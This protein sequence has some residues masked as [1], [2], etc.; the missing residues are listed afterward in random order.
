MTL[1]EDLTRVIEDARDHSRKNFNVVKES[2]GQYLA[3]AIL[4]S[5]VMA[6]VRAEAKRQGAEEALSALAGRYQQ[7]DWFGVL[8]NFRF[9]VPQRLGIAQAHTD[10]LRD[11]IKQARE[12]Q[13]GGSDE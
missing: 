7:N 9:P 11:Q 4:A 12:C 6:A 3:R 13:E 10:W 5:D 1:H 2:Y 8:R